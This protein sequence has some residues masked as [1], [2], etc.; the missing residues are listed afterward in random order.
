MARIQTYDEDTTIEDSDKLVGTDGTAGVDLNKTKNFTLGGIK[1]YVLASNNTSNLTFKWGAN[2]VYSTH[3]NGNY[4]KLGIDFNNL[5]LEDGYTYTLLIDRRRRHAGKGP[6]K[7][8]RLNKFYHENPIDA[9]KNSRVSEVQVTSAKGQKF[10][11]NQ[12]RYFTGQDGRATGTSESRNS[13]SGSTI[14]FINL[15]FRLR[16]TKGDEVFETASL[17]Q[18]AMN[19]NDNG[20]Q[21]V[22]YARPE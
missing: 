2:K 22:S 19:I 5:V 20:G 1:K 18:I 4:Y 14:R 15:S 9:T 8:F 16:I 21:T 17:G 12:D 6:N 3:I 13:T 11:F 10:D 7:G